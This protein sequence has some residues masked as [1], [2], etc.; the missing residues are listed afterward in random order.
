MEHKHTLHDV[1]IFEKLSPTELKLITD[2][3]RTKRYKKS[4]IIFL[5]GETFSGFYLILA[6]S[7][8]LYKLNSHG[9]EVTQHQL[10]SFRSFA[11]SALFSGSR[12]YSTCAQAIEDSTLLF[13][14]SDE[15]ASL[16]GNNPALAIRI[17]EAFAVRLMELNKRF[18]ILAADVEG[19]VARYLLNEIQLNN[20]V[21]LPEPHFNLMIRKKD[22]AEHLG[23]ATETL[24]RML[25]KF[26]E[27]KI[28]R[29]VSK[30][31]FIT[32][33]KR[34]RELAQK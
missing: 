11:E 29:E 10:D 2:I 33:V 22:L 21:K 6:G 16:L 9:D 23:I 13:F 18:D 30:K 20:S 24:S 15:F 7:V 12:F 17:S 19:R 5:E 26:K 34:L 25:R 14:P 32:D 3:S 8:K 28:I 27:S 31:I 1:P 4:Q